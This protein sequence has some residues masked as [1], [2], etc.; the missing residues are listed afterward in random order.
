MVAVATTRLE[1]RGSFD[2]G[3]SVN[4]VEDE[5]P[6]L[7]RSPHTW[8]SH[9][10]IAAELTWCSI[11]VMAAFLAAASAASSWLT[12]TERPASRS[13]V[14]R[15]GR[16]NAS[17]TPATSTIAA[18]STGVRRRH[19]VRPR[20][21]RA[22]RGLNAAADAG[23]ELDVS[24]SVARALSVARAE[25]MGGIGPTSRAPAATSSPSTPRADGLAAGSLLRQR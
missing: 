25:A 13:D 24:S 17:P 4:R 7:A 20:L 6:S 8:V 21:R 14:A 11:Q 23:R 22:D 16:L 15:R 9:D 5:K 18:R 12:G 19:R 1:P 10:T 3:P 2:P